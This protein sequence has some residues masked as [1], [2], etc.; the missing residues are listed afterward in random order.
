MSVRRDAH[1]HILEEELQLLLHGVL[2]SVLEL[3]GSGHRGF[4]V[5]PQQSAVAIATVAAAV[6]VDAVPVQNAPALAGELILE[7]RVGVRHPLKLLIIISSRSNSSGGVCDIAAAAA[8][9]LRRGGGPKSFLLRSHS[10]RE[11]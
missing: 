8:I 7:P 3:K 1:R 10:R 9:S 11:Q 5:V 6:V 4:G 2:V